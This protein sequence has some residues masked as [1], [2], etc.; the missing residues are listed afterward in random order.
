MRFATTL[1]LGILALTCFACSVEATRYRDHYDY[2]VVGA[3]T[4]GCV[5]AARLSEDPSVRVLL[6]SNGEDQ[7]GR[8][9]NQLP[10]IKPIISPVPTDYIR[11]ADV[12]LSTETPSFGAGQGRKS[13]I[14]LRPRLLGGGSSVNG[15]AFVRPDNS[16]YVRLQ[17]EFGLNH[18]SIADI[19]RTWLNIET[20]HP[21]SGQVAAPGHGING[22]INTR[23]ISP[24]AV[25]SLYSTALQNVTGS[26]FNPDMGLGNVAGSGYTVRPLGGLPNATITGDYVR[27]DSYNR[28]IVPVLSRRNLRVVDRS[29]VVQVSSDR[30]CRSRH[31]SGPCINTVTYFRDNERY[32]V[33]VV[34]GGEVILAAGALETPKILM[35]SGIGDCQALAEH[36]IAC[37]QDIPLMGKRL[38]EH[39]AFSTLH[40]AYTA[41]PNWFQHMGSLTS[42]YTS[43][44]PDG[45]INLEITAT[46]YPVS[47]AAHVI[48]NQAVVT[49]VSSFGEIRLKDGDW[50][51]PAN[52][53]FG[54]FT[55]DTDRDALLY[56]YRKI[57]QAFNAARS[58]ASYPIMALN[59]AAPGDSASDT[60]IKTWLKDNSVSDYHT[61][62]TTPMGQCHLGATLDEQLRVCGVLGLRVADNGAMPFAFTAHST[63]S[64]ALII[65]EQVAH[66]IKNL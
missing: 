58:V 39:I 8:I 14:G 32:V 54:I 64:G 34:R 55:N 42:T 37:V 5:A 6:V 41:S 30:D 57:G 65:G 10:L 24:D 18:W 43:S 40:I 9:E 3:G 48:I 59:T 63:H 45:K 50:L 60:E 38:Q 62:A 33:K 49:R 31:Q 35:Q 66:F 46:G 20:F 13:S 53:S 26:A 56:A 29:T 4:A 61:V 2:I 36:D 16:D 12:L 22:P 15:G 51:S 25:L 21:E 19:N 17:T 44:R 7:T 28:Y 11:F 52:V 1:L 47:A 23:A 27:Q